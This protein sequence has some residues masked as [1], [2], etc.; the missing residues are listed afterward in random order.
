MSI[1][2][3]RPGVQ[4]PADP[5]HGRPLWR[6]LGWLSVVMAAVLVAGSLTAY[7]FYRKLSGNMGQHEV[8]DKLGD[9]PA[10]ATEAENILLIGSDSRAGEDGRYGQNVE[11]ARSDTL[12]LLHLSASRDKAMMVSFPRDSLVEIPPCQ[13]EDGSVIAPRTGLLNE[14]FSRGG[15]ACSWRTIESLTGVRIDHFAQIDFSGF[16]HMI[17]ALGGVEICLPEAVNDSKAR[18]TLPA[19]RHVVDGDQALAYVRLRYGLGDGSDLERIKRQQ[20]FMAA[21]IKKATSTRLL[22]DPPRL[23]RFLDAATQSVTTDR[24]LG[25]AGL[26]GIADSVKG[27]DTGEVAFVTVPAGAA[28]SD[29]NRLVWTQPAADELFQAIKKDT[30]LSSSRPDPGSAA[31][32]MP[33]D[34]VQVNVFNGTETA[35]LAGRTADKLEA[36]GFR[37]GKVGNTPDPAARTLVRHAPGAEREA[38]AVAAAVNNAQVA[39]GAG[40]AGAVELVIGGD[41]EGLSGGSGAGGSAAPS[42]PVD[43]I[44][45]ADDVCVK[46]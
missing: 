35:G 26:K 1:Q 11:G 10:E 8:L 28:P 25:L 5:H 44:T 38:Q 7:G 31:P 34:Q 41:W 4:A 29:P 16:K 27:I 24:E 18:L 43:T 46:R 9:R 39:P 23:Y 20:R 19:G 3:G 36:L 45:A 14:A 17:D 15:P 12:I 42:S 37:V 22:F 2:K 6:V 21:V 32:A 30:G 13:A 40:T 33:P